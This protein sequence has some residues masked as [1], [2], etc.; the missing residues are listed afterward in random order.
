MGEV[1]SGFFPG[2]SGLSGYTLSDLPLDELGDALINLM[3]AVLLEVTSD[4]AE[5]RH[6]EGSGNDQHDKTASEHEDGE[7]HVDQH[8]RGQDRPVVVRGQV[9]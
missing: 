7:D 2:K 3:A 8:D 6:V 1:A 9:G 5:Q 4:V